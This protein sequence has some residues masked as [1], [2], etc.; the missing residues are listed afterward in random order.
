M[1]QDVEIKKNVT[2]HTARH[3]FGTMMAE[4]GHLVETQRMMGHGDIKTTME[5]QHASVKTLIDAK[6]KRFGGEIPA[7]AQTP[8]DVHRLTFKKGKK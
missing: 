8:P 3:T 4:D 1:A 2:F 6:H 5:Y 7:K